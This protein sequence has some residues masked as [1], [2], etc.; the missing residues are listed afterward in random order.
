[1]YLSVVQF[2]SLSSVVWVVTDHSLAAHVSGR[3]FRIHRR[4]SCSSPCGWSSPWWCTGSRHRQSPAAWQGGRRRRMVVNSGRKIRRRRGRIW[5]RKLTREDV[6]VIEEEGGTS[7]W[8]IK[9]V[10]RTA[11]GAAGSEPGKEMA[12]W[13]TWGS[14]FAECGKKEAR[15]HSGEWWQTTGELREWWEEGEGPWINPTST[16]TLRPP[17][18]SCWSRRGIWSLFLPPSRRRR[19]W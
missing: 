16:P 4:G 10:R 11:Q 13:K 5:S 18:S 1:M 15:W 7:V 6:W 3:D 12:W 17:P 14:F 8:T 9:G 2:C 19:R